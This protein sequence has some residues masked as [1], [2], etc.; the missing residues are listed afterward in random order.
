M[1]FF[2]KQKRKKQI[3]ENIGFLLGHQ[4]PKRI[5]SWTSQLVEKNE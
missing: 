3:Q 2:E 5:K 4:H 1:I